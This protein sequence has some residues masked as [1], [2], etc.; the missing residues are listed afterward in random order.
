MRIQAIVEGHGEVRAVPLLL[1]RLAGA[2]DLRIPFD[3]LPPIRVQKTKLLRQGELERYVEL[4]ARRTETSDLILLLVDGDDDPA[5]RLGPLLRTRAHSQ[6]P[7]RRCVI[8]VASREFESWFLA[9]ARSIRGV[10]GL[11]DDL[12][13]PA[14]P[15]AVRGAK[16]WLAARMRG[17]RGYHPVQDQPALAARFDLVAARTSPSFDRLWR[18]IEEL[19]TPPD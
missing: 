18:A 19:R 14:E 8:V 2:L 11:A 6:R 4:A 10:I 13:P 3:P 12:Q 7:D 17:D 1:R 15:E 5:C 9:A 16:E